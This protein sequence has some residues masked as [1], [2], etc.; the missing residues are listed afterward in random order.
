MAID[1]ITKAYQNH[2]ETGMFLLGD[3]DFKLLIDAVKDA[4][5]KTIGIYH[6]PTCSKDLA[7]SFDMRILLPEKAFKGFLEEKPKA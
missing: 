7:R 3:R 1:A 2:Y 5:K 6:P 4:G